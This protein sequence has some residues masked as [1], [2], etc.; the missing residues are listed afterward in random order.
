[1]TTSND[2]AA[3][4]LRLMGR[5][6]DYLDFGSGEPVLFIHGA[7]IIGGW[8]F[9]QAWADDFRM[10][11]PHQPGWRGSEDLA[12]GAT[13][14]DYVEWNL[15]LLDGLGIENCHVVGFSMGGWIASTLA[16]RHPERVRRLILV[17]PAG[18]W[19]Q[20]CPPADLFAIDPAEILNYLAADPAVLLPYFPPVED[21]IPPQVEQYRND[22]AFAQLAWDRLGDRD[23][24]RTLRHI[25]APTLLLWGE[26]DRIIP[27]SQAS[28]WQEAIRGAK[29]APLEETGHYPFLEHAM[30]ADIVRHFLKDEARA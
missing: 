18:Y 24:L 22:G 30:A 12:P 6:A 16:A 20:E 1:M 14:D 26:A 25:K 8:D 23:H 3:K 9:A 15:A 5:R 19:A 29:L 4:A 11:C 28:R 10:I 2:L 17:A 7:G 21:P 27:F 13:I